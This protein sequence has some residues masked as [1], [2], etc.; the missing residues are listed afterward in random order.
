MATALRNRHTCHAV[1]LRQ[2]S[3]EF[4]ACTISGPENMQV[5]SPF[6]IFLTESAKFVGLY[7]QRKNTSKC[8]SLNMR[9]IF[10]FYIKL[11]STM[12]RSIYCMRRRSKVRWEVTWKITSAWCLQP[13]CICRFSLSVGWAIK[14]QPKLR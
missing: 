1:G 9:Q 7:I 13:G 4:C 12:W 3:T 8:P 11:N 10:A 14:R 2:S 6:A 5:V